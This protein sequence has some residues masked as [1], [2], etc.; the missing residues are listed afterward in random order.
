M[1]AKITANF[2]A[3]VLE[4][5]KELRS[6]LDSADLFATLKRKAKTITVDEEDLYI[7]EGDL[8]LD[9]AELEMYALQRETLRQAQTLEL[10]A[11][12][13]QPQAAV[14]LVGTTQAGKIVRWSAGLKLTFCVLEGTFNG[15]QQYQTVRGAMINATK[16]WESVCGIEFEHNAALDSSPGTANPG[17]TFTVRGI[18]A[19]G[20]FIASAFFPSDPA[21]RRR[22][23]IDPSYFDPNMGFNQTGVLRHELG[24]VLG[25]RHEHIRSGAPAGCPDEDMFGTINLGDYDPKS[26]MHYFCGGVGN[27]DLELTELDREGSQKVYGRPFDDFVLVG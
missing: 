8:T 3:Q 5:H 12:T 17:V 16:A 10:T 14:A 9:E 20:Q 19:G 1:S 22:V 6:D 11:I 2:A 25:F 18:N 23:L 21:S 24:H 7:V 26:V 27:S 15:A 13:G 4:E